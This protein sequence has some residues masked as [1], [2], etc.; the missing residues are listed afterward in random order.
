[1]DVHTAHQRRLLAQLAGSN[2]TMLWTYYYSRSQKIIW[3]LI[4]FNV[5]M[6]T[7]L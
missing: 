4:A 7:C 5:N 1:M 2:I 6:R 3:T